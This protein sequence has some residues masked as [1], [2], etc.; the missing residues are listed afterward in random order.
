MLGELVTNADQRCA[1]WEWK[2]IADISFGDERGTQ[3]TS[4]S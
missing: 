4:V 2:D 3:A 1:A